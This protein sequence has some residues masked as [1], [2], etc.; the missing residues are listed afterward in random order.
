MTTDEQTAKPC[1]GPVQERQALKSPTL[2]SD[3]S[4][5]FL[6]KYQ[7]KDASHD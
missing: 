6:D 5:I 1:T 2:S 4:F 7:I 3:D